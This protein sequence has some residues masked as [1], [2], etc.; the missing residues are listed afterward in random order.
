VTLRQGQAGHRRRLANADTSP[1]QSKHTPPAAATSA[2]S[3][4]RRSPGRTTRRIGGHH[5]EQA[6][7]KQV[8]AAAVSQGAAIRR[9]H[10]VAHLSPHRI[11]DHLAQAPGSRAP[12]A[13]VRGSGSAG[14]TPI[15]TRP[16]CG[17]SW[18]DSSRRNPVADS[19]GQSGCARRLRLNAIV[20]FG[21]L[22]FA[23]CPCPTRFHQPA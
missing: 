7:G 9:G 12:P 8:P 22:N 17:S 19:G 10:S 4:R 6:N 2:A 21:F 5:Q 13:T 1:S 20:L 16:G 3:D 11:G 18:Q 23:D 14:P 15:H